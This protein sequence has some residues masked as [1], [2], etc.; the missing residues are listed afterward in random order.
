MNKNITDYEVKKTTYQIGKKKFKEL[1]DYIESESSPHCLKL[2]FRFLWTIELKIINF[3]KEK[4]L[5]KSYVLTDEKL[6]KIIT[7][8]KF[9]IFKTFIKKIKNHEPIANVGKKAFY[10]DC[11][12]K[13]TDLPH[14]LKVVCRASEE[15][16]FNLINW[17]ATDWKV[18]KN[19][20]ITTIIKKIRSI[21]MIML[22]HFNQQIKHHEPVFL[23]S[24]DQE[25]YCNCLTN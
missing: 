20:D 18:K 4:T 7:E 6:K 21:G 19:N 11:I 10:C 15:L 5:K 14:C 17:L 23:E 2:I 9:L 13:K 22:F 3:I 24:N 25:V 1:F 16:K 12:L 8:K